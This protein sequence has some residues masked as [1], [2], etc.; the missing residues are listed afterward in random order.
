MMMSMII[1]DPHQPGIDIDVY[2]RPLVDDLKTLWSE[3]VQVYDAYKRAPFTLRG[4]LFTTITDIL[5]G[6]SVPGQCKGEKDCPHY[7]DDT[8]T[9]W[10]NNSKKQVYV[11]HRRFLPDSHAY[12]QMKHQ[13]DG[14]RELAKALRHFSIAYGYSQ[15]KNLPNAHGKKSTTTL[16]KRKRDKEAVDPKIRWKKKSILW[17]LPY[18]VDLAV[19]HSID[20]MHVKKKCMWKSTW[21]THE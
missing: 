13:F 16:R 12:R 10:L 3:G 19:Y 6:R 4:L 2:L 1:S 8:E 15:V 18:W 5:G 17:E 9:L 11:R 20:D 14:T 7:L 21:N